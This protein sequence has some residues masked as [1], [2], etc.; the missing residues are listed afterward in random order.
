M[1]RVTI[2]LDD[3]L[4]TA[5]DERVVSHGYQGRSE[6]V[7]DLLRAGLLQTGWEDDPD[8]ACVARAG[9]RASLLV[10]TLR[11]RGQK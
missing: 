11:A 2:T 7:R 5:I 10:A 6:A 3:A 1:Q 9:R 8:G 4:L